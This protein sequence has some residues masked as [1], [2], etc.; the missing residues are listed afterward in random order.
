MRLADLSVRLVREEHGGVL[1]FVAFFLPVAILFMSFVLD[2][3]NWFEHKRHLQL[4][5]DAAAL[6][7]AGSFRFPCADDPIIAKVREYSGDL[8]NAQVGGTPPERVHLEINSK[9]YYN[10]AS[11]NDD[12]V[13]APPCS[14]LMVDVKMTETDVPWFFRAASFI[15]F[16]NAHARVR[17]FQKTMSAGG[18]PIGVPDVN[19][20]VGQVTFINERTRDVLASAPLQRTGFSGGLAIWENVAAAVAIP[21]DPVGVRIAFGGGSSTTCGDPLVE[22]YDAESDNGLLFIH[23]W[24]TAGS[25]EQPNAPIARDVRLAYTGSCSDPYF[26]LTLSFCTI[27]IRANVDIGSLPATEARFTAAVG[28]RKYALSFNAGVWEADGIRVDPAEG[29]VD[30]QVEWKLTDGFVGAQDCS[31]GGGCTGTFGVVQRAFAAS[32]ARSGPIRVAQVWESGVMWANSLASGTHDLVVKVGILGSLANAQTVS[33]PIVTLRVVGGSRNQSLDCDPA[34]P[35]LKEELAQG[36]LPVYAKNVGNACPGS[37]AAL[38]ASSQPWDCVAIQT[39]TARNQVAEGLNTRIL[40]LAKPALCTSPNNW[41]MFPALP[42]GDPRILDV[43]LTPFGVF[44]GSGSGTVPV[45]DFATF[46]VTG[47]TGQ[48]TG[49]DNPCEGNGDDPVPN[50]NAGYIVGHFIKYVDTLNTG[51]GTQPCDLSA[52]GSCVAVLTD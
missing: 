1:V 28:N 3:G 36:C 10:Q 29:P 30:F 19:P 45:S 5:A 46:Y 50:N 17:I 51:G 15:P 2:V 25:G 24:S 27:G 33:D 4:Q 42:A 12:T 11:P 32:D 37:T 49:F 52:L 22:C 26:V 14:A 9:N 34:L 35:S 43:F 13:E 38:W 6:A 44:G 40:G 21:E 7:G 47:W 18:L 16:I 39:G 20:K 41:S 31:T 23:G 8:Y 48:G